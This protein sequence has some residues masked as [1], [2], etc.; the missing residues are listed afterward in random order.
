ML[1]EPG[2]AVDFFKSGATW[3]DGTTPVNV[4]GGL[5]SKGHP[6]AATGIANIWEVATHL[7]G[8][9]RRPPDR[10]RQ[11]RPG[12]RHRARLG[13]RR[14]HPGEV[15]GLIRVGSGRARGRGHVTTSPVYDT[16][17]RDY[18]A[19]RRA[20]PR[21]E[22]LVAEQIGDARRRR[23]RRRGH[24]L[25]R[26]GRR[27]SRRRGRALERHAGQRPSD[28]APAVRAGAPR[29][30]AAPRAAPTSPWPSC[31][32]HHWDDWKAGLAELHRVAR[33]QVIFAI[34]FEVHSHVLAAPGLPARGGRPHPPLPPRG[35]RHRGGDRRHGRDHA[36]R[37]RGPAGR[38]AR[39]L[40]V[41]T[42]GVSRPGRAGQH[43]GPGPGRPGRDHTGHRRRSSATWPAARGSGATPT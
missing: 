18:T 14:A 22:A 3:R 15:G 19:H 25:L 6:I 2:G 1:C 12:P 20:D 42:R 21:W 37:S 24:G 30:A 23:Q 10:G 28:A 33:R 35:R 40:L 4:S 39:R 7:R 26:A 32:V 38:R 29:P 34:D 11:G 5:E 36:A 43:L 17:G 31:T 41:P 16:I 9:A 13:L 27:A 8:E